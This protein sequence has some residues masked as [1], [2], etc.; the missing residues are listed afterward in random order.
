MGRQE[1]IDLKH[2]D[3]S[4]WYLP[5][6]VLGNDALY[7]SFQY[8]DR[9]VYH[10]EAAIASEHVRAMKFEHTNWENI[11]SYYEEIYVML[12]SDH[13]LLSKATIYL[14]LD[15]PEKAEFELR[16]INPA[17]LHQREYLF[18]GCYAEYY[19][20]MNRLPEA[21]TSIDLAIAKCTNH[22]EKKYLENRKSELMLK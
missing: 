16:Q 22:F 18:H 2:Q 13:T 7:K 5:L 8:E 12:P 10:Y 6:I 20:N 1:I 9:S 3:R 15:R 11:L 14:Q 17:G 21:I 19:E 4:K